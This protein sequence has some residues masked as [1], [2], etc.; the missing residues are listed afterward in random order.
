[1]LYCFTCMC[2]F[3]DLRYSILY[4]SYML[5]CFTTYK[6]HALLLYCFTALLLYC[7][8]IYKLH[9]LLLYYI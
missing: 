1:M 3:L 5:Y 7:F 4:I 8:T 6:L 2:I 9:A